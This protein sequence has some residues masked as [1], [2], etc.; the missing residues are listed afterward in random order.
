MTAPLMADGAWFLFCFNVT[1]GGFSEV[2]KGLLML[3]ITTWALFMAMSDA[4]H[5]DT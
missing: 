1:S 4:G 3:L 2:L 5:Y